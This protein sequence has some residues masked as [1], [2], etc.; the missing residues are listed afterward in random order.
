MAEP[1]R[2]IWR[3]FWRHR[4]AVVALF[5]LGG[6]FALVWGG[7]LIWRIDPGW[8]DMEARNQG[9]SLAHPLGTD[10]LGRDLL[11][12]LMA[13]GRVSLAVGVSAMALSVALGCA[14]GVLAGY[15][16]LLDAPLMR[17]T[18]LFLALPLLPLLLML[19]MLFQDPL[20][21]RFGTEQGI[22]LLIVTAIAATSWMQTARILRAEVLGLKQREFILAARSAGTAAMPMI[23]RHILPN[24]L[25]P[26]LVAATLCMA[27][28]IIA[29][30]ALSFLGYG[31]PPDYPTWGRLLFD[32]MNQIDIY[33]WR[34]IL[35]GVMI[36]LTVLCV[37]Y[38]GDGLRDA[39]DPRSRPRPS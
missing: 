14:I 2:D 9:L 6:I 25:S 38:I 23:W 13:G 8:L 18:E 39:M 17:L 29:E 3:R 24:V 10:H 30:S 15:V 27:A 7:P 16:R 34:A 4:G 19:A 12:R 28:A 20:T 5:V 31:F 1:G 36:S 37:N 33:P 35:P 11:A 26:I 21:R 32:A 22:F